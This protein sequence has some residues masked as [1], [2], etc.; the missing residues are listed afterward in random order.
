MRLP[1]SSP[2]AVLLALPALL[3]A[4][5]GSAPLASDAASPRAVHAELEEATLA[6]LQ[7]R[8]VAGQETA[9]SLTE[10]YLARIAALDRSGPE[11]HSVIELN[12]D[13]LSIADALDRE[14]REKGPRGPLHGIPV[15]VKDNIATADRLTTTAGSLALEG[16]L[17]PR[18]AFVVHQ[19]RAAGAVVL[20]KT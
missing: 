5:C 11:L 10:K 4:A 14:R 12:P 1:A 8:L 3:A 19:L 16:S 13:A 17:S 9:R 15:L 18:D 20:G 6:E 7:R 2:T